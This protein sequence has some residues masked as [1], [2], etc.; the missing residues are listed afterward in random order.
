[1][2]PLWLTT[3]AIS[4]AGSGCG[5]VRPLGCKPLPPLTAFDSCRSIV[6][7]SVAL[8]VCG[9]TGWRES[10]SNQ[11][12]KDQW[13]AHSYPYDEVKKSIFIVVYPWTIPGAHAQRK[14]FSDDWK[15]RLKHTRSDQRASTLKWDREY[16]QRGGQRIYYSEISEGNW[17]V[18]YSVTLFWKRELFGS[19]TPR[20]MLVQA[21]NRWSTFAMKYC[22]APRV[23][24][25][26]VPFNESAV[27]QG[28]LQASIPSPAGSTL[29]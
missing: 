11:Y 9:I 21:A 25:S 29:F 28:S 26:L 18:S 24:G 2:K 15:H 1:M 13:Q 4:L 6:V 10:V 14:S 17:E 3:I 8:E 23:C 19:N 5:L 22:A 16:C 12:E 27:L 7:D 20:G